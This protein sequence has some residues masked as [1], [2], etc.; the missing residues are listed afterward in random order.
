MSL[1]IHNRFSKGVRNKG[2]ASINQTWWQTSFNMPVKNIFY[3][4]GGG[5]GSAYTN[6]E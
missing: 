1:N 6:T 4:N 3:D 2:D 5:A